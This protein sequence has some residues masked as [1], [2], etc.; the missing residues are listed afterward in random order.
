MTSSYA[1]IG[2]TTGNK[3]TGSSCKKKQTKKVVAKSCIIWDV[4]PLDEKT[5]CVS[6]Q[7]R[8]LF[9]LS[10]P[11]K[12]MVEMEDKVRSIKI[13]GLEWKGCEFM[14]IYYKYFCTFFQS[15]H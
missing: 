3:E 13:E 2:C 15:N 9:Y 12:D 11:I 8:S 6:S 14:L 10:F 5:G 4:K 7:L 1:L